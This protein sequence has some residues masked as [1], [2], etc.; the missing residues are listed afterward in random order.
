M[1]RATFSPQLFRPGH[2]NIQIQFS[3]CAACV[4][5]WRKSNYLSERRGV[6][7]PVPDGGGAHC[8]GAA[9]CRQHARVDTVDYM[10]MHGNE[11]SA[12][13]L[14]SAEW[15]TAK[16]EKIARQRARERQR[17]EGRAKE[18]HVMTTIN[19]YQRIYRS[20]HTVLRYMPEHYSVDGDGEKMRSHALPVQIQRACEHLLMCA[21]VFMFA[22]IIPSTLSHK[23]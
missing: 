17:E 6:G 1:L 14:G 3:F 8:H 2:N 21:V 16:S 20:A 23:Y 13:R 7:S 4:R 5:I 15:R 11:I 9:E 12:Y 18:F 19:D 22:V 10:V